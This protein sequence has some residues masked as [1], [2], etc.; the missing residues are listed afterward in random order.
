MQ[1]QKGFLR[2]EFVVSRVRTDPKPKN[3]VGFLRSQRSV[4]D[5]DAYRPKLAALPD[6]FEMQ[7]PMMRIGLEELE[8][9]V[10]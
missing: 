2:Q 6:F 7:R 4:T 1:S 9:L 8:I 5:P 3:P 10:G